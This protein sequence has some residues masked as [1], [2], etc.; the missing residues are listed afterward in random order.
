M[1]LNQDSEDFSD[2]LII[3][4]K[5]SKLRQALDNNHQLREK[6]SLLSYHILKGANM[7]FDQEFLEWMKNPLNP[8]PESLYKLKDRLSVVFPPFQNTSKLN[9]EL[10]AKPCMF[11]IESGKHL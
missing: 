3:P 1:H 8:H 5:C 2:F 11:A 4:E 6:T 7:T 9:G 10:K